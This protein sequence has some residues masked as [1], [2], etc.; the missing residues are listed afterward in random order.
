MHAHSLL[1]A[2][3]LAHL[4]DLIKYRLL[5]FILYYLYFFARKHFMSAKENL[6]DKIT[7]C[8][9]YKWKI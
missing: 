4:F 7:A 2:S 6:K 5:F 1:V 3:H 8:I 9:G